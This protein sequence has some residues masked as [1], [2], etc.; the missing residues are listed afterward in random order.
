MVQQPL[1]HHIRL[2]SCQSTL[3]LLAVMSWMQFGC[4]TCFQACSP[5]RGVAFELYLG[6]TGWCRGCLLVCL[7][8]QENLKLSPAMLSRF[9][10]IFVLL[11]RPDELMDQALSEHI[12]ALHSGK[13]PQL[14]VPVLGLPSHTPVWKISAHGT[15]RKARDL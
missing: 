5:C 11:D 13:A 12:M 4:C 14:R 8:S 10:L 2:Q 7:L 15:S 6:V 1:R 9:D 3:L